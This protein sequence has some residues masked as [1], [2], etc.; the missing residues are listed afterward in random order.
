MAAGNPFRKL[1]LGMSLFLV[2]VVA[3]D[4]IVLVVRTH[5]IEVLPAEL[6]G[7]A[8]ALVCLVTIAALAVTGRRYKQYTRRILAGDYLV[9]WHYAQGEWQQFVMQER[10]RSIRA[11][12]I[13]FPLTLVLAVLL[14]LLSRVLDV[15]VPTTGILFLLLVAAAFVVGL[16][17]ALAGRKAFER[18]AHLA[19]DIYLSRLGVLRPDRYFPLHGVLYHLAAVDVLP[20]QPS[21]LRF[22]LKLG[23]VGNLLALI[24]NTPPYTEERVPVPYGHEAEAAQVAARIL[25]A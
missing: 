4:V 12:L 17:Y 20:G 14:A 19:G 13:F 9:R 6:I 23:W 18:R 15:P 10:T 22:R 16:V 1:I 3:F 2:L 5:D 11:A 7:G 25:Q 24:G 21:Q 8:L